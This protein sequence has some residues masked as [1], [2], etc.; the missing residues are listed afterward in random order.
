MC[1]LQG[2]VRYY[3]SPRQVSSG[4]INQQST[5]NLSNGL[6]GAPLQA[7]M[8]FTKN[9]DNRHNPRFFSS[10]KFIPCAD[11]AS[12]LRWQL[13]PAADGLDR[14]FLFPSRPIRRGAGQALSGTPVVERQAMRLVRNACPS[15]SS[16]VHLVQSCKGHFAAY[17]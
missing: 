10:P 1:E 13:F 4:K 16:L 3:Y 7:C 17:S 5:T 15:N 14:A 11:A 8:L 2:K 6:F 9:R 12:L